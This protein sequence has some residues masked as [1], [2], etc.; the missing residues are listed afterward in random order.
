MKNMMNRI[1]KV[2]AAIVVAAVAIFIIS[3]HNDYTKRIVEGMSETQIASVRARIGYYATNTE[4][5]REYINHKD[6][7]D[8]Q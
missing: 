2:C 3:S 8:A 4:I 6:Y 5:A 1:S 7:Y